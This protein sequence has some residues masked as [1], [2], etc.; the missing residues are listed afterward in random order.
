M[1][2]ILSKALEQLAQSDWQAVQ[3]PPLSYVPDSQTQEVLL[4]VIPLGPKHWLVGPERKQL[5]FTQFALVQIN[6][7]EPLKPHPDTGHD[8]PRAL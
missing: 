1:L 6:A 3:V 5:R 2:V 7:V 8:T 4:A